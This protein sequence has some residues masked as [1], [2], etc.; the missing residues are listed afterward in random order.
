MFLKLEA[1]WIDPCS[2]QM[3]FVDLLSNTSINIHLSEINIHPL[4]DVSSPYAVDKNKPQLLPKKTI[5][6]QGSCTL[7]Y[8]G[9][10]MQPSSKHM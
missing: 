10:W 8:T 5:K 6:L 2:F 9:A 1:P 4:G 3:R 7:V